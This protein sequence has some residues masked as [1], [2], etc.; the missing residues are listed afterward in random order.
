MKTETPVEKA[1][2]EERVWKDPETQRAYASHEEDLDAADLERDR[3]INASWKAFQRVKAKV[4]K[5]LRKEQTPC[6]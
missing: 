6:A 2:F 4:R 1:D 5:R 3:V